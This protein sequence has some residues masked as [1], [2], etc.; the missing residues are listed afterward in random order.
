ME[1]DGQRY[2]IRARIHRIEGY[3][4]HADQNGLVNFIRR[5]RHLPRQVRLVHGEEAA[6]QALKARLETLGIEVVIP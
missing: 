1:L 2:D 3:S 5:M 4:A 6:K